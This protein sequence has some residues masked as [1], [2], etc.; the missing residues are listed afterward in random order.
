MM[1]TV[2][3]PVGRWL[4]RAFQVPTAEKPYL[5]QATAEPAEPF[6]AQVTEPAETV[7]AAE[8]VSFPKVVY[9]TELPE[10]QYRLKRAI[11]VFLEQG[12]EGWLAFR[13]DLGICCYGATVDEALANF[14]AALLDDYDTYASADPDE[15]TEGARKLADRLREVIERL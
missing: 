13:D 10:R 1:V 3:I 15:L 5:P 9:L 14:A 11:A 7:T 2:A 6:I 8:P 12:Q 4:Q